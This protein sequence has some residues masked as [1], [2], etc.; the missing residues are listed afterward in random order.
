VSHHAASLRAPAEH[1]ARNGIINLRSGR[2]DRFPRHLICDINH[3]PD[4]SEIS[5]NR[6]CEISE[7]LRV[8]LKAG[9]AP[10]LDFG[11]L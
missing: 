5:P 4:I 3:E 6:F 8:L 2:E 7:N 10:K 9:T 11:I 1:L